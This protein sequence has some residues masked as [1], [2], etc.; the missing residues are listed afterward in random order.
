MTEMSDLCYLRKPQLG[1]GPIC[2]KIPF[3]FRQ[4]NICCNIGNIFN[5]ATC[6]QGL[7]HPKLFYYRWPQHGFALVPDKGCGR[8]A[9][10]YVDL[11]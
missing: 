1:D 3:T 8:I 5:F 11:F 4:Y 6:E 2:T 10:I 7:N 9:K